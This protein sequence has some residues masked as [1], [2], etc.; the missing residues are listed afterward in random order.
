MIKW[1][2]EGTETLLIKGLLMGSRIL[3][4]FSSGL[5]YILISFQL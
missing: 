5:T 1:G 4:F 2:A 3:V